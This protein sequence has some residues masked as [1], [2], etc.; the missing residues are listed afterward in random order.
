MALRI[1]MRLHLGRQA[2]RP[3]TAATDT[4]TRPVDEIPGKSS[5]RVVRARRPRPQNGQPEFFASL[6]FSLHQ[7]KCCASFRFSPP[8]ADA[9]GHRA[10]RP[11]RLHLGPRASRPHTL[12]HKVA[13]ATLTK[14]LANLPPQ[15]CGRDARGP[16]TCNRNFSLPCFF[17][18]PGKKACTKVSFPARAKRGRG[19]YY[20]LIRFTNQPTESGARGRSRYGGRN[21]CRSDLANLFPLASPASDPQQASQA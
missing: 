6:P 17:P 10:V 2:F 21:I 4:I 18:A 20:K 12:K 9:R 11:L 7:G 19:A 14:F 15:R 3:H 16:K 13:L 8:R 5:A 1:S